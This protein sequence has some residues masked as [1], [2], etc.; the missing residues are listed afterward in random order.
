MNRQ[1][2]HLIWPRL[3][4]GN[5]EAA[6]DGQ[7]LAGNNI[8]V[9]FNCTKDLPFI[10][11]PIAKYRIPVDD[12]LKAVEI[13]NLLNWSPE[14]VYKVLKEYHQ[15]KTILIHCYAGMQRSAAVM[16]MTLI[17]LTNKSSDSVIDFIRKKRSVAFF[18]HANFGRSIVGYEQW[19]KNELAKQKRRG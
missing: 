16:A 13:Q 15:G 3:W 6:L 12:N 9:V 5:K 19:L 8:S 2:A 17:T 18:P 10:N 1:N 4:L 14:V 11:G 7:F